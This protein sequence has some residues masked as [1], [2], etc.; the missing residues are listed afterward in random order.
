EGAGSCRTG[1]AFSA[2]DIE[3]GLVAA[4]QLQIVDGLASGQEV[5]GQVEDV[6][7][8]EVGDVPLPEMEFG[9][10]GLGQAQPLDQQENRCQASAVQSLALVGAIEVEVVRLE[11]GTP[12]LFQLL[13]AEAVS[14]ATLVFADPLLYTVLHLKYLHARGKDEPCYTSISPEMLRYFKFFLTH[15]PFGCGGNACSG[16][17]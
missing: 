9:V 17:R 15:K 3:V 7:G 12:L 6:V 10:E 13:L 4:Q 14:D 5:V 8:L 1:D 16:A 2:Q 11:H